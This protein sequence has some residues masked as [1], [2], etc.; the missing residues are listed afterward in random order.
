MKKENERY[1]S[2]L[3]E[4]YSQADDVHSKMGKLQKELIDLQ[5]S[6]VP[7]QFDKEKLASEKEA[8]LK[9]NKWLDEEDNTEEAQWLRS[10]SIVV[11]IKAK[12]YEE[13]EEE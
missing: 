13:Q 8:L 1:Q 7:L 2:L 11:N 10:N 4:R 5:A 12:L 6:Q 9:H 3:Q